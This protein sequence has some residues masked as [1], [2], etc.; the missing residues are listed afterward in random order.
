VSLAPSK[1][2]YAVFGGDAPDPPL[3]SGLLTP[4]LDKTAHRDL[5]VLIDPALTFRPHIQAVVAR[6]K[7]VASRILRNFHTSNPH[8][9][10]AAFETYARPH[11]EYAS[12]A[13][14]GISRPLVRAI[15]SVQKNFTWRAM[16]RAGLKRIPYAQR[17]EFFG[18]ISLE[19]RLRAASALFCHS[20]LT[21]KHD[22][23]IIIPESRSSTRPTRFA[24][25]AAT[26]PSARNAPRFLISSAYNELPAEYRSLTLHALK[27]A[28]RDFYASNNPV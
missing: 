19:N 12:V 8:V 14:H 7:G 21:G 2:V 17:L 20:V 23:P 9:L 25:R 5:G 6:V 28:S 18:A 10:F 4:T 15:E 26:Q 1:C 13:F 16:R 27:N 3:L 11:V 22:C 24:P